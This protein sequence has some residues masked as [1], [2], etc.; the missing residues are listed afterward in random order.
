MV[1]EGQHELVVN[2]L[3][4]LVERRATALFPAIVREYGALLHESQGRVQA[5]V[6]TAAPLSGE[7]QTRLAASLGAALD[8]SVALDVREAPEIIGGMVV[9]VGD[10]VIDGSVRSRLA[11]LRRQLA[12]GSLA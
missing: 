10:Q 4:L 12:H 9:R 1:A 5:S 8:R 7:Q 3:G 11:A 6:A 2:F